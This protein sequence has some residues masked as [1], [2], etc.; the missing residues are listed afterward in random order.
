MMERSCGWYDVSQTYN[1]DHSTPDSAGT[2][3]AYLCGVKANMGTIGV[4]DQV[5]YGDCS[6]VTE[7]T[8]VR[9]ILKESIAMGELS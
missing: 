1:V 7:S 8:K 4:T 3:T 9:S 5:Q 2:A 6:A